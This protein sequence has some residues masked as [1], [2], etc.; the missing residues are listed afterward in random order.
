[1][2]L[3]GLAAV[4]AGG[5]ALAVPSAALG[6]TLV[7]QYDQTGNQAAN[8]TQAGIQ[9]ASGPGYSAPAIKVITAGAHGTET[10]NSTNAETGLEA[11]AGGP[12]GGGTVIGDASQ[13]NDQ[14]INSVQGAKKG[15]QNSTNFEGST[16]LIVPD[17]G[18]AIIGATTQANR[19]GENS[20]Q[21]LS[22]TPGGGVLF[23]EATG[24]SSHQNSLNAVVDFQVILG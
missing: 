20:S 23:T 17:G 8:S 3:R 11:I 6:E 14:A 12:A 2:T 21:L 4:L 19:Q 5:V 15:V 1:M 7:G 24:G 13:A 18:D 10:Q 16:E 9:S 22:S